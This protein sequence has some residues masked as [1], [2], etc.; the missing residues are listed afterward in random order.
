MRWLPALGC[1]LLLYF[2][3]RVRGGSLTLPVALLV[4]FA[5]FY[6]VAFWR[7]LSLEALREG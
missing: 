4:A 7:G 2:V 3:L 6:A 1:G 5:G